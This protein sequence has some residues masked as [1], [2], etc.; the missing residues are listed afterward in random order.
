MPPFRVHIQILLHDRDTELAEFGISLDQKLF[1]RR[2]P[3][4]GGAVS[5]FPKLFADKY[6]ASEVPS[7]LIAAGLRKVP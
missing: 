2:S 3:R 5:G 1:T 4:L 7:P 6:M